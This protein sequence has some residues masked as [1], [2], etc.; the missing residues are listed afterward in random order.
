MGRLFFLM[1]KSSTG[2]DSIYN[3]LLKREDLRLGR[4]VSYTTR[5]IRAGEVDGVDY[6]FCTEEQK[7]KLHG[8]NRIVEIRSYPT[9]HG[10]WDYFT[11]DDG[12]LNLDIGD[13]A[14]IGTLESFGKI[15]EYYKNKE[16]IP[17]YIEVEDGVRLQRAIDR[18][19]TQD[20]PRYEELCRRFLADSED[21][22]EDKLRE[23]G[24]SHRFIN[25][26]V[27]KT[28]DSIA[29]FIKEYN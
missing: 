22:S 3:K 27:D 26:D 12:G 20:F 21:F 13:Y 19:K 4:V 15:R 9:I 11:V 18:E 5:P 8:E 10:N 23:M 2:K 6:H 7:N 16:I 28:T 25:N 14:M 1:G 17:I 29:E 24:I